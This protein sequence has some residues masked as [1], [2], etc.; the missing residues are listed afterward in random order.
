LSLPLVI[1]TH[2][3][4][5]HDRNCRKDILRHQIDT[6]RQRYNIKETLESTPSYRDT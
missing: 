1:E 5:T 2:D 3:T 4:M 6:D